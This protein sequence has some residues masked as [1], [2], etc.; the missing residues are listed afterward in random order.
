MFYTSYLTYWASVRAPLICVRPNAIINHCYM[1]W[2]ILQIPRGTSILF[3]VSN[4]FFATLIWFWL[5]NTFKGREVIQKLKLNMSFIKQWINY[6][7]SF[8]LKFFFNIRLK[9]LLNKLGENY[10]ITD[11]GGQKS[12]YALK[13]SVNQPTYSCCIGSYVYDYN[14]LL[15][16]EM[17]PFKVLYEYF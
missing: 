8:W 4:T 14:L 5:R 15:L 12:Y 7:L 17:L 11:L 3:S 16:R 13:R 6:Y 2:W 1:Y 10:R 9:F